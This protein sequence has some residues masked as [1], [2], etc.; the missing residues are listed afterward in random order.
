[1]GENKILKNITGY[2]VAQ[3]VGVLR[4]KPEGRGFSSE[5]VIGFCIDLI[6]PATL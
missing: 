1:M 5:G 4:Y 2:S 6:L 3:L